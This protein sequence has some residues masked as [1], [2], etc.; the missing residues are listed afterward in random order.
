MLVFRKHQGYLKI[1]NVYALQYS[2]YFEKDLTEYTCDYSRLRAA[3][4]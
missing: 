1:F 2:N 3:T 4:C